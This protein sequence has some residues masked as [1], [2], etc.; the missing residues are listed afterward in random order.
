MITITTM[1]LLTGPIFLTESNTAVMTF[2]KNWPTLLLLEETV[3]NSR[4]VFGFILA[5]CTL[6]AIRVWKYFRRETSS[7]PLQ[8]TT[9]SVEEDKEY[10]PGEVCLSPKLPRPSAGRQDAWNLRHRNVPTSPSEV[11]G[12]SGRQI[13]E[14]PHPEY[15]SSS[16]PVSSGACER[17]ERV[18]KPECI[19]NKFLHSL[20][21]DISP[22]EM[23]SLGLQLGFSHATLSTYA[24][25]HNRDAKSQIYNMLVDWHNKQDGDLKSQAK[26]LGHCL[27][28]AGRSDLKI[29]VY[30]TFN[31]R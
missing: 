26:E 4:Y 8:P 24:Y 19:S 27:A 5:F 17:Q 29:K 18:E 15:I 2:G 11:T 21:G 13:A 14:E 28:K 10:L 22:R 3:H 9:S 6:I 1:S 31:I 7:S 30:K 25:N 12:P 23:M 20:S 16:P